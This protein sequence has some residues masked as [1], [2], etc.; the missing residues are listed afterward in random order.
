[1][2]HRQTNP[3][4]QPEVPLHD[5]SAE[6]EVPVAQSEVFTR[7]RV[8]RHPERRCLRFAQDVNRRADH[9]D[10]TCQKFGIDCIF[11][12]RPYDAFNTDDKF[13]SQIASRIVRMGRFLRAEHRLDDPRIVAQIDKD[14]PAMV[15]ESVHPAVQGDGLTDMFPS[16]L[17][18]HYGT[19]FHR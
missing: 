5:R 13:V 9:L 2:S 1:L 18:T 7:V 19:L 16:E 8:I 4:P 17:A 11:G 12:S 10:I 15:A 6:V 3:V 14:H